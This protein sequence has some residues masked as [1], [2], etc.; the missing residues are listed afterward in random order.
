V[1]RY[2]HR[3][4]NDDILWGERFRHDTGDSMEIETSRSWKSIYQNHP[5]IFK[6]RI[7]SAKR[8]CLPFPKK[9]IQFCGD[10]DRIVGIFAE[11]T[12]NFGI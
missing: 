10:E 7:R 5:K 11:E 6:N 12:V 2:L 4:A 9:F 8:K 1:S 3:L